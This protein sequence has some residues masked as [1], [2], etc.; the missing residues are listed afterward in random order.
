MSPSLT[1]KSLP[2]FAVGAA[3]S[4]TVTVTVSV[5]DWPPGSVAVSVNV[6][7]ALPVT[8]GAAKVG[9]EVDAPVNAAVGVPPVCVHA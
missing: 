6:N 1:V 3:L 9:A 5:A 2:A 8:C 4:C 7:A